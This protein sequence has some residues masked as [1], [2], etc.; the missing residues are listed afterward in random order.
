MQA[1]S[2]VP[3]A[4]GVRRLRLP[5]RWMLW[6]TLLLLILAVVGGVVWR[7]AT[8]APAPA[9]TAP[10][11][12]ETLTETV[13]GSG[14]VQP[15]RRLDV[16]FTT[17]GEV[18]DV[19]VK[20]GDVV[21]AGQTLARLDATE[22]ELQVAQAEANLKSAE[23]RLAA[24]R[25][26]GASELD[27]RQA[28]LSLQAAEIQ[29]E[30]VSK[31]N[32]TAAD[33]RSAQANLESARARLAALTDPSQAS[34]SAAETKLRQA[35]AN[36]QNTRDTSSLNKTRAELD[37]QRAVTALTQAQSRYSIAK[38]NWEFV[39][40]TGQDPVNPERTDAS[41]RSVPNKLNDAQ[42]R[43]YYD[44]LVQVEAALRNAE[45]SVEQAKIAYDAARQKEVLDVAQAEQALRDAQ[46]QYD[47]LLNPSN[48]DVAQAQA[49][50]V[51]AQ[52]QLD[53]LT[54]GSAS[55]L[56]IAAAQLQV[57]Q[58]KLA[59]ERLTSPASATE[60]AAAEAAVAQ[61][62][63]QYESAKRAL[64]ATTLQA[65]FDGVVAAVH[66]TEGARVS[67]GTGITLID[68]DMLS[69]DMN[70]SETDV[71]RVT[72]GQ[73]VTLFFDALPDITVRGEV[74]SVSPVATVQQNVV[75]FLVRVRFDP[76]AAPIKIGMSAT[77]DILV[78]EHTDALT[79]PSRAIQSRQGGQFVQVR[80]N[81][82][83]SVVQVETGLSSNGRTEIVRCVEAG[84][85]CLH[86]GDMVVVATT[87]T[88]PRPSTQ[89]RT[90]L[91]DAGPPPGVG[92]GR[93]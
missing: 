14:S 54:G 80:A 26:E 6:L 32:A 50:V 35:E 23:A 43:E 71:A 52:A 93:P 92:G 3:Q 33:I 34:L 36:L 49:S 42:R 67:G 77:G 22:L 85:L 5:R 60:I 17:S 58:A 8:V 27:I 20:A 47:A 83:E 57:E 69:I 91:P 41:G 37:L 55:A 1:T 21:S 12:R 86:E 74:E 38:Q 15:A 11:L 70:L 72:V 76:G 66:V 24:A 40:A 30:K 56:D 13:S 75:T 82:Y 64:Q 10:V 51:Q 84:D 19:L 2:S 79:V 78:E 46:V 81:G 87:T 68:P 44:A 61:A 7:T 59:L 31:G 29:L 4:G 88:S 45:A 28:Q 25:G 62:R 90:I 48:L 65:P 53:K 63:M 9:T 18:T 73:P 89:N 39:Q 16:V